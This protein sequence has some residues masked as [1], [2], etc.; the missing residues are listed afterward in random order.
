MFLKPATILF[1]TTMTMV[2]VSEAARTRWYTTRS[3]DGGWSLDYQN[4]GIYAPCLL[5]DVSLT[6]PTGC[7]VCVDPANGNYISAFH[8]VH[9]LTVPITI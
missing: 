8:E 3:C 9:L 4:L 7:N 5:K 2:S 1:A 6:Y